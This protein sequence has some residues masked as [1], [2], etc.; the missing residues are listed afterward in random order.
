MKTKHLLLPALATLLALTGCGYTAIGRI[1]ADPSRFMNRTVHISGVVTTSYGVLG[2]G[3]YQVEDGSGKIYVLSGTG[4]PSKGSRVD[5]TGQVMSGMQIGGR[6]V[7][8][9][10]RESHHKVKL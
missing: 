3:G 1:N 10:L 5:V 8:T 7:G 2:T 6:S 9:A 4:V